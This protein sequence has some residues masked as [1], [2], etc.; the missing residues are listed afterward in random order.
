MSK[1]VIGINIVLFFKYCKIL[2]AYHFELKYNLNF[3][4]INMTYF[5]RIFKTI[6]DISVDGKKD[7]RDVVLY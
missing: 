5:Y 3:G 1:V 2:T 7:F 6:H 4:K